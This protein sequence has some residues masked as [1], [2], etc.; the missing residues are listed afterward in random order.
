MEKI[1]QKL[2]LKKFMGMQGLKSKDFPNPATLSNIFNAG[3][4]VG[5]FNEKYT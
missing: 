1:V 5:K 4:S 3:K 2:T